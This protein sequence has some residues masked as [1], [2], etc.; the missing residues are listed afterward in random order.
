MRSKSQVRYGKNMTTFINWFFEIYELT[1]SGFQDIKWRIC[2]WQYVYF[3]LEFILTRNIVLNVGELFFYMTISLID[4]H[5]IWN[6]FQYRNIQLFYFSYFRIISQ[7]FASR[8]CYS[9]CSLHG[10]QQVRQNSCEQ[11]YI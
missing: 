6:W 1:K 11:T 10:L 5:K 3:R 7:R 8:R 4:F 2:E 9:T